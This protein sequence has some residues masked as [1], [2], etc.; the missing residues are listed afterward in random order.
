MEK[1]SNNYKN[2]WRACLAVFA[3][4]WLG[5]TM[6]AATAQSITLN[7]KDAELDAVIGWVSEQTGKNF[8]VDPRVKSKVTIVSGK[9]LNKDEIYQVFLSVLQV[10]GFAAVPAGDIIK[11]MPDV[12]AKQSGVPVAGGRGNQRGDEM[13]TRVIA[14]EN[15]PAAQLVPI[16]RPLIPQQGH[17]VAYPPSNV[18]IISDR[19]SNI[20]RIFEIIG[21]VDLPSVESEI[22]VVTLQHAS[23]SEV[24]RILTALEQQNQQAA[25]RQGTE[26]LEGKSTIVADDRSNSVLLG[27]GKS[28]RIRIRA[29]IS[30]L[31][32]PLERE[33]DIHVV[34]LRY[35]NAKE[36]VPVLTG[37]GQ[38]V[39][40]DELA[41]RA[42]AGGA[43]P[44]AAAP[45]ST[46]AQGQGFTIQADESTNALVITAPQEVFRPLQAVIR[47]LDVRRA[48]VVVEA[49][50]AEISMN[51]AA[52]LGVQWAVNAIPEGRGPVGFTNFQSGS[53]NSLGEI[54]GA[55][56]NA[57]GNGSTGITSLPE[58]LN[59]AF[60]RFS[61]T[62][63]SFAALVRAL[64]GDG[65]TNVLSTPTLVTLDNEEA[66]IV[67]G[68]NVPFV[69]GSFT[70]VSGSAAPTNPFQTINRQNV[71]L[72][73][74]VKPQINEGNTIKLEVE[75]KVDSLAA[76]IQG[77]ADLITNTRSIRTAVLVDDGEVVV[78]GGLIT[79][80]MREST[81]K[82]PLL[83][84]LPLLGSLFR[85]KSTTKEKTNLMVFL[86]P[87]I[88][89]DEGLLAQV[90][91]GKYNFM[92]AEQLKIRDKGVALMPGEEV[93]VMPVLEEILDLPPPFELSEPKRPAN[94]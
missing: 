49:V 35:A 80:N 32:I 15:V 25:Q 66:E 55:A 69:T 62:G 88:A 33:G 58:G 14:L 75:Q 74:K 81:Q 84:D 23:A 82:V 59:L 17:M 68:Q 1:D 65:A 37:I 48:Q 2:K 38:S 26:T 51:K 6:S 12:N 39:Q 56:L 91:S 79:D 8:V 61:S 52:Q 18:L 73:L 29:I 86:H 60:G 36:M 77:A 34:Y 54:A 78:L 42:P 4:T 70:N 28:N 76:G 27:G 41:R 93:P 43:P 71:G 64:Q 30:H 9:A 89:R 21:R 47:Q 83:G 22:E 57:G 92:R 85:Y 90:S 13:V 50:I 16:L 45:A 40:Q 63:I 53:G 87:V 94:D 46:R 7:F 67:V 10:H 19:A 72:T 31:D 5:C 24:V 20:D 3:I 44:P 11:I